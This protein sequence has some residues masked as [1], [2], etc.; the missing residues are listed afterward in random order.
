MSDERPLHCILDADHNVV[1]I[2]LET[3]EDYRRFGRWFDDINGRRVNATSLPNGYH[4]STVCLGMDHGFGGPPLWFET[5]VGGPDREEIERYAT[6]DEAAQ[7]H[8]RWCQRAAM[9]IPPRKP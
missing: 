7:G 5:L 3:D 4:V 2:R 1:P 6:W 8:E 9:W